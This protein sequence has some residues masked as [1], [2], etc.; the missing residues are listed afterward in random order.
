[1]SSAQPDDTQNF[2][3][4]RLYVGFRALA[5]CLY[6]GSV[7]DH[8]TRVVAIY[9][10]NAVDLRECLPPSTNLFACR[11]RFNRYRP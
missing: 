10:L 2:D 5:I 1:M 9:K 4:F 3:F 8:V 11:H 6:Q 7:V